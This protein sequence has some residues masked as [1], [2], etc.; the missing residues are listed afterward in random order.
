MN[1]DISEYN[2][3]INGLQQQIQLSRRFQEQQREQNQTLRD[4]L[5]AKAQTKIADSA[6][7]EQLQTQLAGCSVAACG[8]LAPVT[9][10]QY[11]WSPS[12]QDVVELRQKYDA[13]LGMTKRPLR[14][15]AK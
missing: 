15:R 5:A 3:V 1:I 2:T 8:G 9:Q 12:Y 6:R 4:L 11:G 7:I 13:L 10:D 14:S